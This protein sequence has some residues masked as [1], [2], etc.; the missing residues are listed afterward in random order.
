MIS[1]RIEIFY[2]NLFGLD[3]LSV[4]PLKVLGL[5][6]KLVSKGSPSGNKFLTNALKSLIIYPEDC[7][8]DIGCAKGSAIKYI[9]KFPFKKTD[10]IE[11]S[12]ELSEI[13][14]KNFRVLNLNRIEIFNENILRFKNLNNYNYF[15]LYNP[16]SS[17]IMQAFIKNLKKQVSSNKEIIIIYNNPVCHEELLKEDFVFLADLPNMWGTSIYIY[18]NKINSKRLIKK[19]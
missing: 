1:R 18:S 4:I 2:D 14:R 12:Q 10:G 6:E 5:D 3:L 9:N 11:I 19:Y 8:L 15:Y 16:F 7:I 17:I 13:A